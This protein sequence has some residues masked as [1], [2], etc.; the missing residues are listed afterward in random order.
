MQKSGVLCVYAP[1][2]QLSLVAA[3]PF[4]HPIAASAAQIA[5]ESITVSFMPSSVRPGDRRAP[6]VSYTASKASSRAPAPGAPRR[7]RL[8]GH[9]ERLEGAGP[10]L[11]HAHHVV[12]RRRV[13]EVLV[14][15]RELAGPLLRRD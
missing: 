8:R 2:L 14:G 5:A 9:R 7:D 10:L 3:S 4:L 13:I 12:V 6:R 11:G 1:G 15:D